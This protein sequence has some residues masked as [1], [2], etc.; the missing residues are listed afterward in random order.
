MVTFQQP[1]ALRRL[2]TGDAR[3]HRA[4]A[5]A[6]RFRELVRRARTSDYVTALQYIDVHT[7]L[8]DDILA[9]VDH[10]SMLVSLETRVP[11]LDHVLLEYVATMPSRLKLVDG[12]GK[13][14]LKR[15]M[16]DRVPPEILD[17]RKMGFGVPLDTWFRSGLADYAR[18]V[19]LDRRTR[20]RG[21]LDPAAVAGLL[22]DHQRRGRDRG[23]QLWAVLLLEEWARRWLDRA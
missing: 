17:R 7:Y 18:D 2:V 22:D 1:D 5:P 14:I 12:V 3:R 4:A 21:I 23:S 20:E 19:L 6:E 16:A 8:P 11:L 13:A 9:K 15:T 10:M